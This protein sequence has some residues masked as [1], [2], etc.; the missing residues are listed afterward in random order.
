MNSY[1]SSLL[2]DHGPNPFTINLRNA[3][4]HNCSSCTTLWSGSSLEL[5]LL[6]ILPWKST[7]WKCYSETDQIIRIECGTALL[8][9]GSKKCHPNSQKTLH[10]GDAVFVPSGTW[11]NLKNI[12]K[13]PLKLSLV[14]Y[15]SNNQT[16]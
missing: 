5:Q 8:I 12:S 1:C 10:N 14:L 11:Y 4:S 13:C 16:P 3:A 7:G 9:L 6:N 15:S 2:F